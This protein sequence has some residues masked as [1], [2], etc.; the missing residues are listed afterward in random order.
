MVYGSSRRNLSSYT[1]VGR[2]HF[3]SH[4]SLE[5]GI[6]VTRIASYDSNSC[7]TANNSK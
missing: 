3:P 5:K 2:W 6:E 1:I 4:V 7:A